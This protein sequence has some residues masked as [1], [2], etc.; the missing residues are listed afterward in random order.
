MNSEMPIISAHPSNN[1]NHCVYHKNENK[2]D[3]ID[4]LKINNEKER[5]RV[6]TN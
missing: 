5:Y 3:G 6:R 1:F 2:C 4:I